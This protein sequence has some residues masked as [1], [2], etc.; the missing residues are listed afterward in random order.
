MQAD[1]HQVRIPANV[2]G[3]VGDT[4]RR[5]SRHRRR[6]T[7]RDG[8]RRAVLGQS[9]VAVVGVVVALKPKTLR[10]SFPDIVKA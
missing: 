10:F 1:N 8:A 4:S 9:Q 6:V 5:H 3:G 2:A 7:C